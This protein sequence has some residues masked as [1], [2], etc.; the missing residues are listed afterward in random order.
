MKLEDSE[1]TL[2]QRKE[3]SE[4]LVFDEKFHGN[5]L[6][7]LKRERKAENSN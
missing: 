5:V 4:Q 6:A 2:E 1:E 3:N 7:K